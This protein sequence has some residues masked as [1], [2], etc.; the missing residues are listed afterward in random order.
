MNAVLMITLASLFWG[1][2]GQQTPLRPVSPSVLQATRYYDVHPGIHLVPRM[3]GTASIWGFALPSA[4][5]VLR[6]NGKGVSGVSGTAADLGPDV[7][8]AVSLVPDWLQADL[9]MQF[10][11]MKAADR[12]RWAGVIIDSKPKY[13]DETGFL[14]AHTGLEEL[15]R[16]DFDTH[17]ITDQAEFIY[18]EAPLLGWADLVEHGDAAAGG[19][20]WTTVKLHYTR[21]GQPADYEVPRDYYYWFVVH[22]RED[23]EPVQTTDPTTGANAPI[24]QGRSWREYFTTPVDHT[25]EYTDHLLF[26]SGTDF[27]Q[28]P[29]APGIHVERVFKPLEHAAVKLIVTQDDD[30]VMFEMR[31]GKGS[32]VATTLKATGKLL[33]NMMMYGNGNCFDHASTPH[34]IVTDLDESQDLVV[35]ALKKRGV[36]YTVVNSQDFKAVDLSKYERLIVAQ[37]NAAALYQAVADRAKDIED[38]VAKGN[39]LDLFL[40][41]PRDQAIDD[42]VFPAGIAVTAP[43]AG[44]RDAQLK[45]RGWPAFWEVIPNTPSMWDSQPHNSMPGDRLLDPDT[46]ALDKLGWFVGVNM[47]DDIRR[48]YEKSGIAPGR[49]VQ[50]VS[51]L[52]H[53]VG[54]CGELEDL[55]TAALRSGLIPTANS[56]DSAEDHVWSEFYINGKWHPM[57][58]GWDQGNTAIDN[59]AISMEKRFGGGKDISMIVSMYGDGRTFNRTEDYT[60]TFTLDLAVQDKAGDP[61]DGAWVLIVSEGYYKDSS[62]K[63][64]LYPIYLGLTGEDGHLKLKLGDNQ[65]FYIMLK[66]V[67]GNVPEQEHSVAQVVAAKDAKKDAVINKTVTLPG[68]LQRIQPSADN[69]G[70]GDATISIRNLG[71]YYWNQ[72]PFTGTSFMQQAPAAP[73]AV[74]VLDEQG[75]ADFKAGKQPKPLGAATITKDAEIHLNPNEDTPLFLV[76]WPTRGVEKGV[77]FDFSMHVPNPGVSEQPEAME[78]AGDLANPLDAMETVTPDAGTDT[79]GHAGGGGC[80]TGAGHPPWGAVFLVFLALAFLRKQA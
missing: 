11:H 25:P 64:P 51:V 53:H 4:P 44:I 2:S 22:P 76:A 15:S 31:R 29:M 8:K 12:Q 5:V 9:V 27:P 30:L 63:Y 45:I 37:D 75:L 40:A 66:S 52:Y 21:D 49:F 70:T 46:F 59:F 33:D 23:E 16:P 78:P 48:Y 6:I 50:A 24:P 10:V 42:L 71:T 47:P 36:N 43:S 58:L 69:K 20:Y 77:L 13:R 1:V 65:N 74:M 14:V 26:R 62:G 38:W 67:L 19:D 32:I 34:L 7:Q 28:G 80:T 18:K 17:A 39:K 57:Q 3:Q 60:D 72:S 55:V 56:M 73:L 68:E 54:N 61:V 79:G 41:A 35:Q